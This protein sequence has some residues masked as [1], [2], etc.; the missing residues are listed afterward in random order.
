M[1]WHVIGV[2]IINRTLQ[3]C[4]EIRNFSSRVEKYFTVFQHLREILFLCAAMEYPLCVEHEA[5]ELLRLSWFFLSYT[6]GQNCTDVEY[7]IK[8]W[9]TSGLR[10][11]KKHRAQ[12]CSGLYQI[13][14][15][16]SYLQ[17][18]IFSLV[19]SSL[20]KPRW[21]LWIFVKLLLIVKS[22]GRGHCELFFRLRHCP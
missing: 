15:K 3:G 7:R 22:C 1:V 11:Q 5:V 19:N 21:I 14:V 8:W 4:L 17:G 10:T 18:S 13:F 2:Y 12:N 6:V 20:Y 9:Y 16:L